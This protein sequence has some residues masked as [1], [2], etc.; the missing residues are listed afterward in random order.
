M[1]IQS[2]IICWTIV[3]INTYLTQYV[4][5]LVPF[6]TKLFGYRFFIIDDTDYIATLSHIIGHHG[7]YLHNGNRPLGFF[8][9]GE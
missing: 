3:Q 1:D 4:C 5:Y 8:S 9:H 7:A 2:I 6:I